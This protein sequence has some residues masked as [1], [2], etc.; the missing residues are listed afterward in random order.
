MA[1]G[2]AFMVS[3]RSLSICHA[4]SLLLRAQGSNDFQGNLRIPDLLQLDCTWVIEEVNQR[5]SPR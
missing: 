3:G 2:W 1:L 4:E 5:G